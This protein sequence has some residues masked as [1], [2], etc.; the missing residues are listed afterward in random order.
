MNVLKYLLALHV[1]GPCFTTPLKN[2]LFASFFLKILPKGKKYRKR[3]FRPAFRVCST[4]TLVKI[5]NT[6][7]LI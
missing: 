6:P 4:Q 1:H 5:Y 3:R 2:A 7:S